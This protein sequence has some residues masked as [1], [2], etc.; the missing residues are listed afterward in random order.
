MYVPVCE[1]VAVTTADFDAL[2]DEEYPKLV[3]LGVSM[4][5]GREIARELARETMVRAHD[6]WAELERYDNPAAWLR[7]VMSNLLIDHHR[8][9]TARESALRRLEATATTHHEPPAP[10]SRWT[11][12]IAPH[13]VFRRG[14]TLLLIA[15]A[16]VAVGVGALVVF[17]DRGGAPT[18]VV[19]APVTAPPETA[20]PTTT[21]PE[22]A[23]PAST[24][25]PAPSASTSPA[26]SAPPPPTTAAAT[27]AVPQMIAV[28]AADPP[29][30]STPQPFVTIPRGPDPNG[31]GVYVAVGEN[32]VAV[33]QPTGTD[34]T[35]ID[36]EV[37]GAGAAAA[38]GVRTAVLDEALHSIV[39]GPGDVI[40]GFGDPIFQDGS[41]IP[42]F[43]YVAVALSGDR[44]GNVLAARQLPANPYLELP[45]GSFGHGPDGVIDRGRSVNSTVIEYVDRDGAP[46]TW[47][48]PDPVMVEMAGVDGALRIS[49]VGD[50]PAWDLEITSSPDSADD[51]VGPGPPAPSSG[52]RVVYSESIG[53]DLTPGQDFGPNAT[54]VV[55]VLEPDGS[56]R[57]FRL[58]DDWNVAASDVWGTV[59]MRTTETTIELALL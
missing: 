42:T 25:A 37:D 5:A 12:H 30:L 54:P 1:G 57:W 24:A 18:L 9:V 22:T 29:P 3:A 55:A 27:T 19:D 26:A 59:L 39:V 38:T 2:F 52:G 41:A 28:D 48:G 20:Q 58:P 14:A 32:V 34:V 35:L 17:G 46:A 7:R 6:E 36:F 4:S 31:N 44:A 8:S 11:D 49:T 51:Y 15:A 13:A 33:R 45:R 10:P 47:S 56:G 23:P 43:R 50:G 53:S 16:T 21:T 40:Y